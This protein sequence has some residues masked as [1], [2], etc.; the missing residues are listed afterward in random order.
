MPFTKRREHV[1]SDEDILKLI[2]STEDKQIRAQLLI[3]LQMSRSLIQNTDLTERLQTEFEAHRKDVHS[4]METGK[5]WMNRSLGAWAVLM[6]LGGTVMGFGLY[7]VNISLNKVDKTE[8]TAERH[9]R[10]LASFESVHSIFRLEIEAIKAE[11]ARQSA[12]ISEL[13]KALRKH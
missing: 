13:E 10:M 3:Q 1:P 11:N 2:D 5:R 4:Y 8:L 12:S 7:V 9:E 6:L